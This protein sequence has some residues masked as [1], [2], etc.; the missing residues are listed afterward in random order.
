MS[1]SSLCKSGT[2]IAS[3]T[4]GPS[5]RLLYVA[6]TKSQGGIETHSVEMAEALS[7]C[8][9][10]V[11]FACRPGGFIERWCRECGLPTAAFRV[12]NSGDFGAALRLARIISNEDIDIVHVHSRRDYVV[13]VLGVALARRRSRRP[14]GLVLHAHMIRPLGGQSRLTGRFIEWGADAVAAVSSAV[15][16]LV[17]HEHQ[18]RPDFVQ[19]I[20]NGV[21]LAEFSQPG[22]PEAASQREDLRESLSIPDDALVI[23]MIGRL[24]AKGQKQLLKVMPKLLT[25]C[26]TLRVVLA[27][28]EGKP[29]EQAVLTALA[30]AHGFEDHLIF[31]GPRLDI[32]ELLSAFDI[33]VHL[34]IDEA[35]GLVIVEAM[36]SGL[37]TVATDIGGCRE[38]VLEGVTGF[39]VPPDDLDAL[40]EAL[41]RLLDP[42]EGASRRAEMGRAGR[43]AAES[44]FS[45]EL[46]IERLLALYREI[47]DKTIKPMA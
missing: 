29:N 19:L 25:H 30:S 5:L 17:R 16:D 2:R 13:A 40:S 47:G 27:G 44:D 31:T 45:Q 42:I 11:Q 20:P 28:S 35:F 33:L 36:A 12:R 23:G 38:V 6:S 1:I 26:P 37:S 10:F 9:A 15:A 7:R 41:L 39:L 18:F 24:D 22:S 34:P 3:S 43:H 21:N 14:I 8:G 32:P 4:N 46:Q